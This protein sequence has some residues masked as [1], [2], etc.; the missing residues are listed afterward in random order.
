[1]IAIDVNQIP[2]FLGKSQ[3]YHTC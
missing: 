1:M 3:K 2:S